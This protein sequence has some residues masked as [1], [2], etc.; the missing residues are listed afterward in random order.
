MELLDQGVEPSVQQHRAL[1]GLPIGGEQIGGQP[2]PP[3]GNLVAGQGVACG[4]V[5]EQV[6]VVV[7][8]LGL[9]R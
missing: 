8:P 2:G 9:L 1:I 4:C 3:V 6:P 7:V 5:V